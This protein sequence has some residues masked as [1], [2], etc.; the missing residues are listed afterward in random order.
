MA[1][2]Q[3]HRFFDAFRERFEPA[4]GAYL[5][6]K[7]AALDAIDAVGGAAARIVRDFI[8][9]GG[10]RIRPALVALGYCAAGGTNDARILQPAVG[11]ELLH[12][13]FLIHDDIMDR[14]EVRRNRP[15]VHRVFGRAYRA[16]TARLPEP[17]RAHFTYSMA[18]L[19]GNLCCAIAYE[20][21]SRSEFPN[22]RVLSGINEIHRMVDAT[23]VGQ[24]LDI[25]WSLNARTDEAAVS[26]MYRLKTASY[27]FDGPL[28]LGMILGGAA[29]EALDA[30]SR[31]ALPVGTAFQ[32]QDDLLGVFGSAEELGK[33][34]TS[35]I[36]EGKQ[37]LLTVFA[38]EHGAREDRERLAELIGKRGMR[39]GEIEE[40]RAIMRRTG[41]VAY[42]EERAREF[43]A[44][45]KRAL[46]RYAMLAPVRAILRQLADY[47]IS[48]TV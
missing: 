45:G 22:D 44:E 3:L 43:V 12:H 46:E 38:R 37:T 5:A 16:T 7:I 33:S 32:I 47:V 14:S 27:T 23:M 2:N 40:V 13:F 26:K 25:V 9:Q 11:M 30:I 17:D 24:T 1:A 6:E 48:R 10:K 36:E 42:C 21:L 34:V 8:A 20:A 28:R 18:M 41:T 15:T 19:A 29:D 4:L 31:Y 39:P 35:D